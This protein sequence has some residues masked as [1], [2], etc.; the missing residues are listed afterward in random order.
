MTDND[1]Y[2]NYDQ[3]LKG[4]RKRVYETYGSNIILDLKK[5]IISKLEKYDNSI[6]KLKGE[7][8]SKFISIALVNLS[9]VMTRL[10]KKHKN[11]VLINENDL[12]TISILNDVKYSVT[13]NDIILYILV[14]SDIN[15]LALNNKFKNFYELIQMYKE[16]I[17]HDSSNKK[18]RLNKRI[19]FYEAS[20]ADMDSFINDLEDDISHKNTSGLPPPDDDDDYDDEEDDDYDEDDEDIEYDYD[21]KPSLVSKDSK[22]F[23]NQIFKTDTDNAEDE[24]MNYYLKLNKKD[25]EDALNTINQI[26]SNQLKNKPIVF[27]IMELPLDITQK[28]HILKQYVHLIKSRHPEQKLTSWFDSLMTIP[29]GVYTNQNKLIAKNPILF[30]KKLETEMNKAVYGHDEAKRQ[31]IQ[32]MGQQI[33]NPNCKGNV[34][35]IYGVHGSGKTSLVKEGIAK[36]L[37][38]PFVF[39][40]LGGA[41]DASFLEGH[42]YTYEGSIYGRIVNGLIASKCMDPIIYF[43]ELDKISKTPKGDEIANILVHLTD[44]IQ[45]SHFRDKYF[46]GIDIDLSKATIIFSFNDPSNVNPILL[47]RITLVETKFLMLSQKLHIGLKYLLPEIMKDMGLDKDNINISEDIIKF[48]IESYTNEGGVRKLKSILYNIV[49]EIN[50]AVLLKTKIN[51]QYIRYPFTL[52]RDHIKFFLK[53]KMEITQDKIHEQP[54][55]GVINGLFASSNGCGGILPIQVLWMPSNIPLKLKATGNLKKV[56]KESTEVACSLAWNLLSDELKNKYS[57]E[58]NKKPNGFHIHCPDGSVPKDGPSA[59]TALTIVL[60]S[61]MS[62]KKI[63]NDLAITGEINLEGKVTAIGGLEEKLE[64]AKKAGVKTVLFPK[65]NEKHLEKIK[66][67][68]PTLLDNNFKA[69]SIESIDDAIKYALV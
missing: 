40:S 45:N 60:Y 58:W 44:P 61:L 14:L 54:K 10:N 4:K 41:T 1:I 35:G 67:R 2:V 31:I 18:R 12:S 23:I 24:I 30:L 3:H 37:G 27:K 42:S 17:I 55:V 59:G 34:L 63:R 15:E 38:K 22:K 25:Q 64:G 51:D 21:Y 68:N 52:N 19:T 50:L 47:D 29:F 36:A 62:N 16:D 8:L 69:I 56:I 57:K 13:I 11:N 65:E 20:D 49:R 7:S 53:H 26:T 6:L 32:M 66:E 33:K 9:F 5:T 39:I 46:H 28:N 48:I 43:D